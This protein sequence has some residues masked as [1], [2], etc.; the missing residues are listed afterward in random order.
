MRNITTLAAHRPGAKPDI[1]FD[2][3]ELNQILRVYG[4][5]VA[6]GEWRDY[7]MNGGREQAVFSVFR[8]TSE[9]PLYS[10][11]KCPKLA[12]KQGAYAIIGM[13]G[14]VLRR[15]HDLTALLRFFDRKRFKVVD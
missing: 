8:R 15:G 2:R 3:G 14:Q 12:R 11:V 10:I 9:M 4:H 6:K 5:M 7:A 1:F 13:G